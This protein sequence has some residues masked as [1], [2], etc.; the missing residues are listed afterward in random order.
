MVHGKADVDLEPAPGPRLGPEKRA[1]CNGDRLHDGKAE[2]DPV[3]QRPGARIQSLEGL[4]QAPHLGRRDD[5]PRVGN[6]EDGASRPG[7]SCDLDPP[8]DD[9]VADRVR[10]EIGGEPLEQV[11]VT[12]RPGRRHDDDTL[13]FAQVVGF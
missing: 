7:T 2:P 1:V 13:E 3:A 8:V 5:R 6:R 10:D 11:R 12:A 9:V 4:E